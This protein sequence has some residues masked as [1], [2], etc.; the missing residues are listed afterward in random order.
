MLNFVTEEP[1]ISVP[2][3]EKTLIHVFTLGPLEAKFLQAMLSTKGWV[4][5]EELPV[6]RASIR[7]MIYKL[8]AKL[9][10]RKVWVIN[11]GRG[12]YSIP[13]SSKHVAKMLIEAKLTQGS[14]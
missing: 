1:D 10:P 2:C 11:N 14:E 5:K 4:G 3:D 13:P 8:R 12:R 9:E 6:V 7:Q